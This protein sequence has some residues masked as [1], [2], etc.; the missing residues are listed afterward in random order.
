ML[1]CRGYEPVTTHSAHWIADPSFRRAVANYLTQ[2]RAQPRAPLSASLVGVGD[3][4]LDLGI[5]LA[6]ICG[7]RLGEHRHHQTV[8]RR[9]GQG[10][11]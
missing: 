5:Q 1:A 8:G 7:V 11:L 2:E 9:H 4:T 6:W 3:H 10:G